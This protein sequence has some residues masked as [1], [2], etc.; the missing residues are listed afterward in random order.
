MKLC[1]I[2]GCGALWVLN[3]VPVQPWVKAGLLVDK[4]IQI[5]FRRICTITEFSSHRTETLLFCRRTWPPLR[6]LKNG[7]S[8]ERNFSSHV[9][10]LR[11]CVLRYMSLKNM[12]CHF[13]STLLKIVC[14]VDF[15]LRD[16]CATHFKDNRQLS[17]WRIR[18]PVSHD[19]P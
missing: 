9:T 1:K 16:K 19:L 15:L 17:K 8:S 4:T 6:Q 2:C 11:P 12:N 13:R 3:R 14:P 5:Y 18:W 7:N 10:A